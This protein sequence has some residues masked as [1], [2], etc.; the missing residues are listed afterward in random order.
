MHIDINQDVSQ[1]TGLV[2]KDLNYQRKCVAGSDR[3][4]GEGSAAGTKGQ[5]IQSDQSSLSRGS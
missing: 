4:K 1:N 3:E 5:G 2:A